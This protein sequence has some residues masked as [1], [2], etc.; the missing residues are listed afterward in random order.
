MLILNKTNKK[1]KRE[2]GA[3]KFWDSKV[4]FS[5]RKIFHRK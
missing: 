3:R 4:H 5:L 1:K 2:K